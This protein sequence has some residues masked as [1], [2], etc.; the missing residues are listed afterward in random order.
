M[1]PFVSRMINAGSDTPRAFAWCLIGFLGI[2]GLGFA[3]VATTVNLD[4]VDQSLLAVATVV[5]FLV[6]NRRPGRAT[7]LFLTMLSAL[8]SLR[9]I[10]WR[11]T[12]T[13]EF[14]TALQ[15]FFGIGLAL[16]EAYAV[17]VLALGYIQTV[18]PLERQPVPVPHDPP[19]WP[20]VDFYVPTYNE[21]L[22][23]VRATVLAAMAIDWPHDKLRVYILDDGRRLA[24]RDFAASCGC[25]YIIRPDNSH[26]KAG[27]LNHAMSLTDGDFIAI[28]D[29]DHIPTRAF[30]QMTMGWLTRDARLAF[31]QTPHHFYSPDPFQR[32]LAAGT[33]VPAEGNMFYGLLQDGNDFWDAAFFCGSCA[34]IRRAALE[35]IGGFATQTAAE[36]AHTAL[37][38]HRK[39]WQSAYIKLP[40]A[41]GLAT[42]RLRLHI[43][44]A[45]RWARGLHQI[46]RT[47][48]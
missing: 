48:T 44:H 10:V 26:A 45:R 33:R 20:P 29:C 16:A 27:N 19:K 31:V 17:V 22:S 2:C 35:T 43:A 18:W 5:L 8:V 34:V 41:S 6:C 4:P 28:F 37:R 21:D 40:L 7:T 1:R 32:N 14:N 39:G 46:L 38:L 13:L 11:I 25:G 23:I 47:H 3:F 36:D 24:F 15:G 12:E 9:Y 42:E 30:L